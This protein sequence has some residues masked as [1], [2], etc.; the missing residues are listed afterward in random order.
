MNKS[1]FGLDEKLASALSYVLPPVTGLA[2]FV[3]EKENKTVRFHAMQA[4]LFGLALIIV[5]TGLG[6]L[7]V[8]PLLGWLA[9]F[10]N[11]AVGLIA[12]AAIIY[13]I[14]MALKEQKYR[15]PII[16]DIAHDQVNK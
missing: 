15:L 3:L 4:T 5:R 11:W 14:M 16:G 8:V 10:A 6:I 1:Y 13:L 7:S 9:R 2:A 12:F